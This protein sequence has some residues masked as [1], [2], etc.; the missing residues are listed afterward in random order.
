MWEEV[1]RARRG[2]P[3]SSIKLFPM[4]EFKKVRLS[5]LFV[6]LLYFQL[7]Y[8]GVFNELLYL[9]IHDFAVNI[10]YLSVDLL[11]T[12]ILYENSGSSITSSGI[13]P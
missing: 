13:I 10:I 8:S 7:F 11:P 9:L 5:D 3:Y 2:L 1:S 6:V 12:K 4:P